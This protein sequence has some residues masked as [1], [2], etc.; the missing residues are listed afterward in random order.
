MGENLGYCS[1]HH[2]FGAGAA[3]PAAWDLRLLNCF[4]K[5]CRGLEKKLDAGGADAPEILV[6]AWGNQMLARRIASERVVE[7]LFQRRGTV[8]FEAKRLLQ[9]VDALIRDCWS[10]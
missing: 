10:C 3:R 1:L 4:G 9:G 6:V 7:E 2:L 8:Q 5:G